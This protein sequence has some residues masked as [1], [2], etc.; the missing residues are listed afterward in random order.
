MGPT[1]AGGRAAA[2]AGD[3]TRSSR[4]EC[5]GNCCGPQP[6]QAACL[7]GKGQGEPLLE[8]G[9]LGPLLQVIDQLIHLRGEWVGLGWGGVEGWEWEVGYMQTGPGGHQARLVPGSRPVA[10]R[11]PGA[12]WQGC[13]P[14]TWGPLPCLLLDA[15]A[16]RLPTLRG[17]CWLEEPP[18]LGVLGGSMSTKVG[19][20]PSTAALAPA[21][22]VSGGGCGLAPLHSGIGAC[23]A[24]VRGWGGVGRGG[25]YAIIDGVC[26][27]GYQGA[28]PTAASWAPAGDGVGWRGCCRRQ[29]TTSCVCLLRRPGA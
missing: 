10:H 24:G 11:A 1:A 2:R 16:H 22:G 23:R 13:I 9:R 26:D 21:G 14:A 4:R 12:R 17:E 27:L 3:G 15:G 29:A 6:A 5:S 7:E 20:R 18:E 19:S 25:W 28:P 8:V